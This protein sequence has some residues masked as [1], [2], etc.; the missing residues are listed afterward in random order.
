M[1]S[2]Q[3]NDDV[4]YLSDDDMEA[5]EL[6][7]PDDI[8]EYIPENSK[9]PK[10]KAEANEMS[11]LNSSQPIYH[12]L[13]LD[14]AYCPNSDIGSDSILTIYK[15]RHGTNGY[16]IAIYKSPKDGPVFAQLPKGS[17]I[18]VN[19]VTFRK[20]TIKEYINSNAF[21]KFV[22]NRTV[23]KKMLKVLDTDF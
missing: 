4:P 16:L 15:Y 23:I 20:N 7:L 6:V 9:K 3:D 22:T 10:K 21:R 1:L 13:I 17:L 8:P 14:R 18:V 12:L 5:L 19:L 2:A 11:R